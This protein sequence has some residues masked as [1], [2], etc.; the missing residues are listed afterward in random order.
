MLNEKYLLV[1]KNLYKTV[2]ELLEEYHFE[3]QFKIVSYKMKYEKDDFINYQ[4]KR[5]NERLVLMETVI[6]NLKELEQKSQE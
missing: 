1:N 2:I 3:T 6:K 4:I 5:Q